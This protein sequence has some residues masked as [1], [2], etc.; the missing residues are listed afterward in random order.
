MEQKVPKRSEVRSAMHDRLL[1][2]AGIRA[3]TC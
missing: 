2:Q 3:E 1:A